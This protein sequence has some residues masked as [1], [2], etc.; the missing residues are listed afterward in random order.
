[1]SKHVLLYLFSFYFCLFSLSFSQTMWTKYPGNPVFSGG[2]AGTWNRHL[3][4]PKVLFNEDSARFEMWYSASYGS[5]NWRPYQIGY[6]TSQDG[7]TWT[8]HPDNPI[9][10]PTPSSWDSDIVGFPR[11]IKNGDRYQMWYS[12]RTSGNS[13]DRLGYA[14]DVGTVTQFTSHVITTSANG[15]SGVSAADLD[16][17][18]DMDVLSADYYDD[19]ITWY[20][21]DGSQNFTA[22]TVETA[23]NGAVVSR[24]VDMDRD[25]DLDVISVA[26][27][28]DQIAW[29]ENDGNEIFTTHIL[30]SNYDCAVSVEAKD[31]DQDGDMDVL[32][33]ACIDNRIFWLENDGSQN[34]TTHTFA[35]G[36]RNATMIRAVDF[37]ND[38]DLDVLCSE[39]WNGGNLL[40]Y[41]NDGSQ[42]FTANI[43]ATAADGF[44]TYYA[45]DIDNDGDIDVVSTTP[46]TD[47]I[48]WHENDGTASFTNHTITTDAD[49]AHYV[50]AKDLDGDGD[51]DV[52][53]SS[54]NDD[55]VTWYE[56]DGDENFT[57][58]IITTNADYALTIFAADVDGDG[59]ID[60]LS[61]SA[62]DNKV[63]WY[64]NMRITTGIETRAASVPA[65]FTLQQN[66]P[67]PFNP[68]TT[69]EFS[70][71]QS[72]FVTL[73][74]YNILGEKVAALLDDYK[75]AGNYVVNFDGSTLA[76]GIYYYTLKMD[77]FQQ[78]R[79]MLLLR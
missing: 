48:Q 7:V 53:A 38:G 13:V 69:I 70:L 79:K 28:G 5:P 9:L 20:E 58:H 29:H 62:N 12:G 72:G 67:N 6:A 40:W 31:L 36:L 37:D 78:T 33:A 45:E 56:N 50:L 43:I 23:I 60:V 46:N 52:I 63:A 26:N 61:A 1:M 71:P 39:W 64:E 30:V 18:G 19:T 76:S 3:F 65:K 49:F 14:E 21:N 75:S 11:I 35:T 2:V 51:V 8:K 41:E 22:H 54:R 57:T 66:Y 42:N 77:E 27:E 47:Q 68:T 15:A 44:R 16:G 10:S 55:K 34:F 25:G 24:A 17:D 73:K 74:V 59:D 32:T 4:G